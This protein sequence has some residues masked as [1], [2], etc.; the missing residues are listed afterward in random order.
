MANCMVHCKMHICVMHCLCKYAL[1]YICNV[2]G[3]EHGDEARVV[4]PELTG[5]K[6]DEGHSGR[7]GVVFL[8][9]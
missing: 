3:G 4:I 1:C 7:F 8:W 9:A 2:E 5:D 6:G